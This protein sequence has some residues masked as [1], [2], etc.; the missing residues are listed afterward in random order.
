[1]H[2]SPPA[3]STGF[4]DGFDRADEPLEASAN[5]TGIVAEA[6][7][8]D[9]VSNQVQIGGAGFGNS[10]TL[11]ETV[12]ADDQYAQVQIVAKPAGGYD[13]TAVAARVTT[14][15]GGSW[16]G[17]I[18]RLTSGGDINLIRVDGGS[19]T[20]LTT[21]AFAVSDGDVLRIE[22]TGATIRGLVNGVERTSVTDTTHASGKAGLYRVVDNNTTIFDNFEAGDL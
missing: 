14:P 13:E 12:L 11:C 2:S 20:D 5:W 7:S 21:V 19:K 17:Y 10:L 1:M 3:P 4:T 15:G 22:C 9:I 16:D 6:G 18:F 8:A